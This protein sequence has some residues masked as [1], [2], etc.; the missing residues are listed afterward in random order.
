MNYLSEVTC[1]VGSLS[2]K[3]HLKPSLTELRQGLFILKMQP[4]FFNFVCCN[5]SVLI[6]S[7]FVYSSFRCIIALLG[8]SYVSTLLFLVFLHVEGNFVSHCHN[9]SI[10]VAYLFEFMSQASGFFSDCKQEVPV[11]VNKDHSTKPEW[12]EDHNSAKVYLQWALC[13]ILN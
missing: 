2:W 10:I 12:L 9:D 5:L 13:S 1:H 7:I 4:K 8:F 6:F 11:Q 3:S